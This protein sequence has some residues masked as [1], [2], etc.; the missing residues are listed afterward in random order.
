MKLNNKTVLLTGA[1]G[2]IGTAIAHRLAALGANL[3]LTGR[4]EQQ[5][6]DLRTGLN[7]SDHR[8]FA[9]DLTQTD[10]RQALVDFARSLNV[11]VLVN[12]AGVNE[13]SLLEDSSDASI[14]RMLSTNLSVPIVL[15]RDLAG[16]LAAQPESAI[17]NVGSIL[18]SIGYAGST[19]YCAAK[20][21]LRGFTEALRRELAD[22]S[23]QVVYVAPRATATRM[24]SS[25]MNAM[26]KDLG[27]A[28]DP[29]ERVADKVLKAI[30]RHRSHHYYLGWPER[31]FVWLN[32]VFPRL[33]DGALLKQLPI[34]Q[35]HAIQK[36]GL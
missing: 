30:H 35:R 11:S 16:H 20:F 15:S 2:G 12:V 17:I 6:E 26:N 13:L 7:G 10:Q 3:L 28:V 21:G 8:I 22:T 18:G 1:S 25:A 14:T 34:I 36:R 23:V 29:P 19:V 33:V 24:N 32:A 9:A 5:L 4:N 27:V 31:F